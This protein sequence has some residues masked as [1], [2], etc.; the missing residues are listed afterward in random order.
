MCV[1]L[2]AL[3]PGGLDGQLLSVGGQ[4]SHANKQFNGSTGIGAR[5]ALGLP[6]IPV[7]ITGAAEYFFPDC[8]GNDCTYWGANGHI[9][10]KIPTVMPVKPYGGVGIGYQSISQDFGDDGDETGTNLVLGVELGATPRV[11]PFI[12]LRYELLSELS[13]QLVVSL[14]IVF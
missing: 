2:L 8:G 4:I 11:S 13:D 5:L 7:E 1:A 14:G 12:E 3:S 9:L 10:L 6:V